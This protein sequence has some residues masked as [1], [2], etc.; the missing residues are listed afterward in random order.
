MLF[1]GGEM[2]V[3]ETLIAKIKAQPPGGYDKPFP[4]VSLEDFFTGNDDMGSIGCNLDEHPGPQFFYSVLRGIRDRREVQDVL[5]T[6]YEI[7]EQDETMWPFS[8]RVYVLT[9]AT[10]EELRQWAAE[11]QPTEIEEGFIGGP[12]LAAPALKLGMKVLSLWWD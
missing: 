4:I 6:I 8:E 7:E 12:P 9:S 10:P 11:L 3:R 5:V 1:C 2:T